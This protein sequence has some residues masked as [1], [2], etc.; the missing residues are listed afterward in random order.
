MLYIALGF[1]DYK[2]HYI[3]NGGGLTNFFCFEPN[4]AC[5]PDVAHCFVAAVVVG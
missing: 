1:S 2:L 4:C 3:P 5:A